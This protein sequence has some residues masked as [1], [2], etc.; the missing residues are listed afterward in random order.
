MSEKQEM[1][2]RLIRAK[3]LGSCECTGKYCDHHRGRCRR[4]LGKGWKMRL[5]PP[6]K[7]F[8][9]PREGLEYLLRSS[10]ALCADCAYGHPNPLFDPS[11]PPTH[12]H[13]GRPNEF[14]HRDP[15]A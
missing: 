7:E 8:G 1:R 14:K 13:S 11:M 9:Q 3:Q 12:G 15:G 2:E 4:G 10:D 6:R 5:S